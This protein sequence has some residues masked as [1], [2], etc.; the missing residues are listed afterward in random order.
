MGT[1][2]GRENQERNGT[3]QRE[4][5]DLLILSMVGLKKKEV[6]GKREEKKEE[7]KGG[8]CQKGGGGE[9]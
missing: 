6:G 9:R 4:R 3:R 5:I 8:I 1:E 7:K 2:S